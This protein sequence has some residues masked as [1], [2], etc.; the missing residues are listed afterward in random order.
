MTAPRPSDELALRSRA[1]KLRLDVLDMTSRAG[2]SHVGSNFSMIELL[3]VLYR[4]ILR[5]RPDD[6]TWEGRDRFILS[7]GHACAALYALLA[8]EGFFP[9]QWLDDFYL[10]ETR[11]AGHATHKG[12]PG[13]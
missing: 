5:V 4:R 1:L 11:L 8:Y 2:S 10:N 12:V 9:T 6:P 3:V 7:K 13:I